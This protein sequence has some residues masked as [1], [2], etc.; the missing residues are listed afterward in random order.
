M[1]RS[2]ATDMF[3]SIRKR[4]ANCIIKFVGLMAYPTITAVTTTV[5]TTTTTV[6]ICETKETVGLPPANS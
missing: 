1:F 3:L 4:A 2:L 6:T 5:T